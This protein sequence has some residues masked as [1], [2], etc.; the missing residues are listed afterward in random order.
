MRYRELRQR[1]DR[2]IRS[3]VEAGD[4]PDPFTLDEFLAKLEARRGRRIVLRP[5]DYIPGRAC[6]MWL[7]LTDVDIIVY[8]RTAPLHEEHIV[9]HEVGHM[10]CRHRGEIGQGDDVMR[11][12]MPDLDPAMV[13]SLLNRGSYSDVEEQEAELF[14]T[15]LLERVADR[16]PADEHQLDADLAPQMDRLRSTF[17]G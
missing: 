8:A 12:L 9:L 11:M 1:C 5:S 10:L 15:L 13:R 2:Q 17:S 6:G 14:A 16:R 3:L 4:L 7:Q